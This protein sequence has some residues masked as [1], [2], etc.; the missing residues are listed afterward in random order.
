VLETS[1]VVVK[2]RLF[3]KEVICLLKEKEGLSLT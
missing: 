3:E 1:I 2:T